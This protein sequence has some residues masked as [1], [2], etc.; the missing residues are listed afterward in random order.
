MMNRFGNVVRYQTG[1]R[2]RPATREELERSVQEAKR[3][4]GYG[5]YTDPETGVSVYVDG[6]AATLEDPC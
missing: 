1:E 2:I 3:D 6:D 5:V 4:G